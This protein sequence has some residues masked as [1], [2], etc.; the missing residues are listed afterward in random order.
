MDFITDLPPSDSYDSIM[1]VVDQG[2]SKAAI[3]MP[4]NKNID[5]TGTATLLLDSL[6]RRYGLL[7]KAI[8]NRGPQFASHVFRE[9]GRLLGINLVMSTAHHPQTDGATERANQEIEAYLSIFC[10]NNPKKW[11]QLLPTLEFSYNTKPHATQKE[12]PLYLQMGYNPTAIP[13]AFPQ[14]NLLDTQEQ[15]LILQ[16]AQK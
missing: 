4:C 14:T 2:S 1:A 16:E 13:T 6:Y 3:F 15:L 8:S 11:R 7:D 9:L 12:S 10:A 5:T